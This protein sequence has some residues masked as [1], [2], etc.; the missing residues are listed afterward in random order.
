MLNLKWKRISGRD[1]MVLWAFALFT[2]F[3]MLFW[4]IFSL[5]S[6]QVIVPAIV[7]LQN[8]GSYWMNSPIEHKPCEFNV[9]TLNPTKS[10][11]P[12]YGL[13]DICTRDIIVEFLLSGMPTRT[14][15]SSLSD[16]NEKNCEIR[17][18]RQWG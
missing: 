5:N 18:L 11:S 2:A 1:M 12:L 16:S 9:F 4:I 7:M 6:P 13:Q 3:S 8:V 15:V 17:Q 10:I 14:V